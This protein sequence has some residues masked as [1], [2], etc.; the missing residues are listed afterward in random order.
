MKVNVS[1]VKPTVELQEAYLSF[2][3]EWQGSG[4]DMVPWV[5]SKDPTNFPEMVQFLLDNE[6]G[7]NLPDGWV[8]GSTYWLVTQDNRIVG[9]VNIRHALTEK[10]W[11]SGG[12]IG[13]GIRPSERRKGYATKLL[14]LSLEK[15][16]EMGIAKA[17]VVCDADNYAS[18][19]TI[20]KNGGVPD[21]SFIEE[22]GNVIKRFWIQC[23]RVTTCPDNVRLRDVIETD[24][25]IFY[26]NQL[27]PT[28]NYMAAFTSKDP[29]DRIAFDAHWSRILSDRATT[30]KAIVYDGQLTGSV[31]CY[32]QCG[33]PE[34]TYWLG[35]EYWGKGIA[36]KALFEFVEHVVQARP[37][38]ARA[39]KDNIASIRVLEKCGFQICGEDKGFS[40]SRG[41][42]VEEFILKLA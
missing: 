40:N 26:E 3:R 1:L 41:H 35:K 9:A 4:E 8:P 6:K 29:S 11:S 2:Y 14:A 32:E 39:A 37:L 20:L 42:E 24:L 27:D 36:S 12:H 30:I 23:C 7:E 22:D 19:R 34:V 13:Y 16:L 15:V 25:P 10:L 31:S 17:L 21:E 5:I 38:Y 28:A 33:Q 18:E